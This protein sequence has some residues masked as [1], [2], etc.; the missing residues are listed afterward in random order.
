MN[1]PI[2]RLAT[3]RVL[4]L[5]LAAAA[6]VTGVLALLAPA[7]WLALSAGAGLLM[8]ALMLL[9]GFALAQALPWLG[10][11]LE[12]R[13][14]SA[15]KAEARKNPIEQLQNELL[16]RAQRLKA[17]RSALVS[18]GA[19]IESIQQMLAAR[20]SRDPGHELDRQAK[21]LD[22]LRQFHRLNLD[23]LAQA[24][25]ALDEFRATIERKESEWQ[26]ACAIDQ[27]S[28]AMDPHATD[29]LIQD[30]LTDTA[31]RTVQDRFNQVFAELDVQ[32]SS[33]DS[34]ARSLL[35]PRELDRIEALQVIPTPMERSLT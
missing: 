3:D 21:A 18:V 6:G 9:G 15:R 32:M 7:I 10:Q 1:E 29:N 35:E 23:R 31:L 13:L 19:Q 24:Q 33:L 5:R 17:F 34:P 8:L 12:N 30:L 2:R 16:R 28:A 4:W 11:M 20:K 25:G 27:A 26:L 14:L 22:R